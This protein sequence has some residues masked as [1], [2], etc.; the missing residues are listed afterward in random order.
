M[1]DFDP[2][3]AGQPFAGF[4]WE[5][6]RQLLA[7]FGND[8]KKAFDTAKELT[9]GAAALNPRDIPDAVRLTFFVDRQNG[10][11]FFQELANA[12]DSRKIPR[13]DSPNI[14]DNPDNLNVAAK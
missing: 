10:T 3:V 1:D 14:L 2:H 11:R 9:L 13:P 4:T 5:L 6:T 8:E 7:R 12:A